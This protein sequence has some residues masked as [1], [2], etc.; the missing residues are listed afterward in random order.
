VLA[1]DMKGVLAQGEQGAVKLLAATHAGMATDAFSDI[2]TTWLGSARHPKYQRPY[3]SLVYQPML[4]LLAY[5]RANGFRTYIARRI[6]M[7]RQAA[8]R[9]MTATRKPQN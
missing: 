5:L 3:D 7:C 8:V 6:S 1:G 2:V 4:E 9:A